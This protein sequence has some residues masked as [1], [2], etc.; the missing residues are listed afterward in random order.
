M[1]V[2]SHYKIGQDR[3]HY[4]S[5]NRVCLVLLGVYTVEPVFVDRWISRRNVVCQD[6]VVSVVVVVGSV[7]Y[8]E[9]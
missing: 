8:I 5:S 1:S 7:I 9:T 3:F 2:V 4:T 6:R